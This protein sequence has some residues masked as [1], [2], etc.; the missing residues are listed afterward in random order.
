MLK[1]FLALLMVVGL[2][3]S[4]NARAE[5]KQL[6]GARFGATYLS[7]G[8]LSKTIDTQLISQYGWQLET[9][10]AD[11]QEFSGLIEWVFLAGG[12]EKGMFLPS[13]SSLFGL[14]N[15][16]GME[17]AMGPNLSLSGVGMV[18][19]AGQTFEK[20]DLN[21]PVNVSWVFSN[22]SHGAPS[23]HRVSLTMGFN[24]GS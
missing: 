16:A 7:S 22:E 20:G 2:C 23:G 8:E 13:V 14:R 12:M 9:R 18:V 10:I 24:F 3:F 15:D 21:I 6:S 17:V 1:K 4:T 11:G 19:A 5:V